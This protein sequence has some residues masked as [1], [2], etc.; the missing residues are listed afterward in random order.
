MITFAV[1]ARIF[2]SLLG[3]SPS[4]AEMPM[5]E[6]IDS[7]IIGGGASGFFAAIHRARNAR[8]RVWI[9]EKS[10]QVLSK[11]KI[12]GGGRCNVTHNEFIPR[13]FAR[14]Y[15]RGE[16]ALIGPLHRFGPGETLHF[17]ESLGVQ[18]KT[19]SDGRIFPT[20]DDSQTIIDALWRAAVDAGVEVHRSVNARSFRILEP[21]E[22][23]EGWTA[24][25]EVFFAD[26]PPLHVRT[27][28][29]A[30]GAIRLKSSERLARQENHLFFEAVPSLFAFDCQDR[31]IEGLQGLSVENVEVSS[32]LLNTHYSGPLL[33]THRGF[34]GPAVLRLSAF[35]AR[36]FFDED[37]HFEISINFL[38]REKVS[39]TLESL[40]LE[41]ANRQIR[42]RSCFEALPRR[43]WQRLVTEAGIKE[44]TRW[45]ELSTQEAE[46][47]L[48]QLQRAKFKVRGKSTNKDEF[49]TAGGIS[50]DD[51]DMR[52]MESKHIPGLY[53][54]GE[55]LNIDGVTGG[56][57]FQNAWTTG[58]QAGLAMASTYTHTPMEKR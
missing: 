32:S 45:A 51:V 22:R 33:I 37:Y 36:H 42:S 56:F 6:L 31:R 48:E 16:M 30:T 25:F 5:P 7:L 44:N 24:G 12:S 52:S 26:R 19:E 8:G 50:T 40:R 29:I 28:L 9:V 1:I 3:S 43:L 15:P 46:R 2:S 21:Q 20:T 14:N 49:V 13:E 11:V 4:N 58:Y 35:G 39:Q 34:S 54:A 41:Q 38:P 23:P 57:N 47:L 17:F 55:V 10:G 18:F 27:L 53:F